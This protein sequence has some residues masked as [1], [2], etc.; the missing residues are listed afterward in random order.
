MKSRHVANNSLRKSGCKGVL[1]NGDGT[2]EYMH[3]VKEHSLALSF[4]RIE[5]KT[6]LFQSYGHC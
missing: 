5:M 3:G 6:D 2:S 1:K 4:F